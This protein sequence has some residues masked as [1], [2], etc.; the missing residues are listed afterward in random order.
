MSM[1]QKL[2]DERVK[3]YNLHGKYPDKATLN[4]DEGFK[5]LEEI[6]SQTKN[7]KAYKEMTKVLLSRNE[8]QLIEL[9]KGSTIFGM[10]IEIKGTVYV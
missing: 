3:F 1:M 10:T 8:E 2:H 4:F 5:L 9:Y 6:R 7:S